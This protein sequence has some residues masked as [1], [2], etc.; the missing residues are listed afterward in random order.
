[1]GIT[2]HVK[3]VKTV[4]MLANLL[5]LRGNVGKPGAGICPVRDHS[6]VQGQRT[7]G[8]TEKPELAPLDRLAEQYSFTPPREQGMNTIETCEAM[9]EGRL[10]AL[11]GLGGNFIRAVPEREANEEAWRKV[12]L[13]VQISTKLNRTHVVHGQ[14]AYILPCLGRTELDEQVTGPQAVSI[15]DSTGCF[16][17]SQ[18]RRAPASAQLRSEPA[19]IAGLAKSTLVANPAV[20]WDAW[21]HDY[22]R[23][24]EAIAQTYPE[25]FTGMSRRMWQPGG[26][27]RTLGA[28]HRKWNTGTGKANFIAPPSLAT[29]ID[30]ATEQR[31]IVQ[32]ITL[33]S[34]DQFNTTVYGYDDRFRGV[35]GTRMVVLMNRNDMARFELDDRDIVTL[36]TAVD[37]GRERRMS[38]FTVVPY[39]IP[40]GCIGGY[41]P[42]CNPLL[43]LWHYAEGSKTPAAKSIPVRVQRVA[44]S[45]AVPLG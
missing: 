13:T 40:E 34:N 43:P 21:V 7:V 35:H 5:L 6:N 8:I 41:Y 2:Q 37:D 14:A 33:R 32:L 30:T 29:D 44:V 42:E 26:F 38:G 10:S 45:T 3:G 36:T 24:R 28:R 20:D 16:H 23:I 15:E 17:G 22:D 11:I 19:I 4:Q 12:Q 9:I 31:D 1:M 18:G 27:H 25:T 39:D